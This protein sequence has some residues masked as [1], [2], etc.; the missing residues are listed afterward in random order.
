MSRK[1]KERGG[2]DIVQDNVD[3][4]SLVSALIIAAEHDAKFGSRVRDPLQT[5]TSCIAEH[6]LLK[7]VISSLYPQDRDGLAVTSST[8]R[9]RCRFLINGAWR[10]VRDFLLFCLAFLI[11]TAWTDRSARCLMAHMQFSD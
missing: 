6:Y 1:G 4:C 2:R 8:G 10:M 11:C 3:D 5:Y 9:H 7:L